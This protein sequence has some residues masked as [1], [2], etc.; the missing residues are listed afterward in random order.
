MSATIRLSLGTPEKD[1][2]DARPGG[3]N[4]PYSSYSTDELIITNETGA[5]FALPHF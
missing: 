5:C 1:P 2:R 3:V 4:A